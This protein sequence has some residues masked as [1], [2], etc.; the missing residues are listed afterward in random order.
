MCLCVCVGKQIFY[1]L[2]HCPLMRL[3]GTLMQS[4]AEVIA[5]Q[6]DKII[7]SIHICHFFNSVERASLRSQIQPKVLSS[8]CA[9][10]YSFKILVPRSH[11]FLNFFEVGSIKKPQGFM[12]VF[13][14]SSFNIGCFVTHFQSSAYTRPFL[15]ECFFSIV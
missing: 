13:Q 4:T 8:K 7:R 14:S 11:T 9:N 1:L 15:E 10:P 6:P 3:S 2:F 5:R 12:K